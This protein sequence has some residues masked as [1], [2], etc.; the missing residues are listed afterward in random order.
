MVEYIRTGQW[1]VM[2]STYDRWDPFC[3]AANV[4]EQLQRRRVV[5]K[6]SVAKHTKMATRQAPAV[7]REGGEVG[8]GTKDNRLKRTAAAAA[9]VSSKAEA[10]L[11]R[12]RLR[13]LDRKAVRGHV[14]R[15]FE[16]QEEAKCGRHAVNNFGRWPPLGQ[17]MFQ[18][19]S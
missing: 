3:A 11:K 4:Y 19:G 14:A 15:Y 9:G 7:T 13:A 17:R 16:R 8:G 10:P 2:M 18:R 5:E 1:K 12:Q 6:K